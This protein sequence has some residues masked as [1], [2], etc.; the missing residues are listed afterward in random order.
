[1]TLARRRIEREL[2]DAQIYDR[3]YLLSN[4]LDGIA[5]YEAG[6]LS[7]VRRREVDLLDLRPGDRALDL[8][9]GRG[10]TAAE[11]LRRGGTV[12]AVDYS[13][14][15]AELT[16]SLVND[17]ALVL[18]ASGIEL[19]FAAGSFDRVLLS[20]VIEHV[21]WRL[22]EHLL[23][24]VYRVLA[25]NGRVLIHTAPNT[26]FIAVVKRPL[27]A[28]LR[29]T[30]RDAAVNRFAE[31]DRLRY[32]MHPNELSPV[33]LRRLMRRSSLHGVTWV[34]RDVLRSGA[35]E[36]TAKWPHF[37]VWGLGHLA[38]AWPMRL[39]L[40]NDMYALAVSDRDDLAVARRHRHRVGRR[41]PSGAVDGPQDQ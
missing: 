23:A 9:C 19:P 22:A 18:Q 16:R 20:D 35:S 1:V 30:R 8:G 12:T 40:G 7:V 28:L 32:A 39:L 24:E 10:E 38:G 27:V 3:D 13:W 26:W 31:Y 6:G 15:A 5:D 36:W 33:S 34:D 25:P 41:V 37:L 17:Q 29:L 11:M 2:P 14:D 4:V 21:P